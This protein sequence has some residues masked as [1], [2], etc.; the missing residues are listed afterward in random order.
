ME[1]LDTILYGKL[2]SAPDCSAMCHHPLFIV[3]EPVSNPFD[4][5]SLQIDFY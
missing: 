3:F 5:T 1:A 2:D 4:G